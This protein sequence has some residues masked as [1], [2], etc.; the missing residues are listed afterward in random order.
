MKTNLIISKTNKKKSLIVKTERI[1]LI[2]NLFN[3][4]KIQ[5]HKKTTLK[6]LKNEKNTLIFPSKPIKQKEVFHNLKIKNLSRKKLKSEK[7]NRSID[8][9]DSEFQKKCL[10]SHLS[11][12]ETCSIKQN[13]PHLSSLTKQIPAEYTINVPAIFWKPAQEEQMNKT[14]P[15]RLA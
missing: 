15:K 6:K 2:C 3:S 11:S 9:S 1:I 12:T 4:S 8:K 14:K 5:D 7:C 10:A 13:I